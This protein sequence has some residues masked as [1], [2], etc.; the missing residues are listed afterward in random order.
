MRGRMALVKIKGELLNK[1][2]EKITLM[3]SFRI[4]NQVSLTLQ[5]IFRSS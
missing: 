2:V 4:K 5:G 1:S 3:G